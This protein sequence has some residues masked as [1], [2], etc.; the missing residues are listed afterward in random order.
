MKKIK[1]LIL[2]GFILFG[3]CGCGNNGANYQR[4]KLN[5][6]NIRDYITVD[7]QGSLTNYRNYYYN[8]IRFSGGISGSLPS[9]EFENVTFDLDLIISK[10]DYHY[11]PSTIYSTFTKHV[12]L[13]KGGNYNILETNKI[14][15]GTQKYVFNS[16]YRGDTGKI[17]YSYEIKNVSGSVVV[18]KKTVD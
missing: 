14:E 10:T 17:S 1:I 15:D 9:Y 13:D 5:D 18:P 6:S 16:V 11:T 3:V 4:I 7:L 8:G 12:S 2:C